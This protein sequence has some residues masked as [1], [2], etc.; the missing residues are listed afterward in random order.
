MA[1]YS[2]SSRRGSGGATGPSAPAGTLISAGRAGSGFGGVVGV[3]GGVEDVL[4]RGRN[5]GGEA[6]LQPRNGLRRI[7][8]AQGRLREIDDSLRVGDLKGVDIPHG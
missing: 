2:R 1:S 4:P 8:H 7:I 6:L 5:D 3:L